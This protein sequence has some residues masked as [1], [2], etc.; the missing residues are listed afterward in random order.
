MP[1]Y[2]FLNDLGVL[3]HRDSTALGHFAFEGNRLATVLREL[4]VHRLMF[5]DDE[6]SFAIAHDSDRAAAFDAFNAARLT[7]LFAHGIM[8]DIAHHID[9]FA[10]YGFLRR[11][12][13]ILFAM[14][15]LL[16]KSER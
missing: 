2:L 13:Q 9:H 15:M 11:G 1:R 12:G 14:F 16:S 7:V 10:G 5:A 3:E 6:I 8:I 4:S